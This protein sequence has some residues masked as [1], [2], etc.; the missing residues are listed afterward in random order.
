M[1]T[2]IQAILF[3][4]AALFPIVNPVGS[5]IIFLSLIKGST[6]QQIN[7]LA[8]KISLYSIVMLLIVLFVG[9][10]ILSIFGVTVP[11]VLISGGLL[12]AQVGWQMLNKPHDESTEHP[13]IVSRDKNIDQIKID[14]D[15][16]NSKFQ[17]VSETLYNQTENSSDSEQTDV[18][19]EEVV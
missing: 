10:F 2:L 12:L 13:Y 7:N 16:L 17:E 15:E 3:S 4:Y 1:M 18:E 19:F 5:S 8:F 9:S 14:L 6:T 11:I